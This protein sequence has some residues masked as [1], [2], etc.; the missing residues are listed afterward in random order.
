MHQQ[1]SPRIKSI[2]KNQ[3]GFTCPNQRP[4]RSHRCRA[5][6]LLGS[7]KRRGGQLPPLSGSRMVGQ[8]GGHGTRFPTTRGSSKRDALRLFSGGKSFGLTR[9][10]RQSVVAWSPYTCNCAHAHGWS[11]AT[12]TAWSAFRAASP[13]LSPALIPSRNAG[14]AGT[15]HVDVQRPG[16]CH[17]APNPF[18][19]QL[20]H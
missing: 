17:H 14:N 9:T 19:Q 1:P 20:R 12:R 10:G 3:Q 2:R 4:L 16:G 8:V 18:A 6:L 15:H 11:M 7:Q 5:P 13:A